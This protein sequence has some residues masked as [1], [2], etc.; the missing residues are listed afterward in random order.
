M[1]QSLM[2]LAWRWRKLWR[3]NINNGAVNGN[4]NGYQQ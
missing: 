3:G 1:L 4:V 2:A